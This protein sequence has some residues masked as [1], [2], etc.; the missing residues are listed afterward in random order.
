MKRKARLLL[1]ILSVLPLAVAIYL[2]AEAELLAW[3]ALASIILLTVTQKFVSA[4]FF[5]MENLKSGIETLKD[6]DYTVFLNKSGTH[7]ANGLIDVYNEMIEQL[8]HQR[9][10]AK[11]IQQFFESIIEK[12]PIAVII[13]SAERRILY[14]NP[15]AEHYFKTQLSAFRNREIDIIEN[16]FLK[17]VTREAK[18]GTSWQRSQGRTFK[19]QCDSFLIDGGTNTA[20]LIEEMSTE[21]SSQQTAAWRKIVRVISHEIQ[22]SI[23]PILSINQSLSAA[24]HNENLDPDYL[25]GLEAANR[26]LAHLSSFITD[27][28]RFAKTSTP[29]KENV[30]VDA[31]FGGIL[32]LFKEA[33]VNISFANEAK[34]QYLFFD[35]R[36]MEQALINILKNAVEACADSAEKNIRLRLFKKNSRPTICIEDT[37]VGISNE[38]K[39]SLFVPYFTTKKEGSGIGLSLVQD[40]LNQHG[41]FYYVESD[42]GRGTDFFIEL[43]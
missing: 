13:L 1:L 38:A 39:E 9:L 21:L 2:K 5:P 34:L 12:M 18:I 16:D 28:S 36:L 19:V 37:G 42:L 31:F 6:G 25:E 14:L 23:S 10:K 43:L 41:F 35:E 26:R 8:R 17:Q 7:E 30:P 32:R 29:Q 27:Y 4:I 3:L 20:F 40:I 11:E 15:F 24:I 22:N 33:P